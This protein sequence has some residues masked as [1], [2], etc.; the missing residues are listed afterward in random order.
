MSFTSSKTPLI[1]KSA[2]FLLFYTIS[3]QVFRQEKKKTCQNY[4]EMTEKKKTRP[5]P[6]KK[7]KTYD[8]LP[9][10]D[11]FRGIQLSIYLFR[12]ATGKIRLQH[13]IQRIGF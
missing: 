12:N 9:M 8:N 5:K 7:S 13:L 3:F 2:I 4:I 1:N 10:T 11:S 6:Q